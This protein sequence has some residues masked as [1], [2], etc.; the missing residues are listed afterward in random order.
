[1]ATLNC[2]PFS[3]LNFVVLITNGVLEQIQGSGTEA[4]KHGKFMIQNAKV[5]VLF[6]M[7]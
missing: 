3:P 1:M 4:L 7:S 5:E 2:S 6:S